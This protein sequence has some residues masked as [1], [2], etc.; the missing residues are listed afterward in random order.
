MD[1]VPIHARSFC[2]PPFDFTKS[3]EDTCIQ[4]RNAVEQKLAEREK[5]EAEKT[6]MKPETASLTK[7]EFGERLDKLVSRNV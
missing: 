5:E 3:N 1:N 6:G 4:L 2:D 7:E